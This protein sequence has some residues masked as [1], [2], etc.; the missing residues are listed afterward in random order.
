MIIIIRSGT[1][2]KY[3]EFSQLLE[4][5]LTYMSNCENKRLQGNSNRKKKE[6]ADKQKGVA[7]RNA[8]LTPM[9]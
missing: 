3:S 6:K 5:V 9:I 8:M 1:E 2:E 7:M 4:D